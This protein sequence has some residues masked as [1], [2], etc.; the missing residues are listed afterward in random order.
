MLQAVNIT[1]LVVY[2]NIIPPN[3]RSFKDGIPKDGI[4]KDG[5]AR[6]GIARDGC[7]P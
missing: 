6:D 2:L 1:R 3:L 5:I 4:P 7:R